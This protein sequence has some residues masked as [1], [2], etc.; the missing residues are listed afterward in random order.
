MDRES[1][2]SLYTG[3]AGRTMNNFIAAIEKHDAGKGGTSIA[4]PRGISVF[5]AVGRNPEWEIGAIAAS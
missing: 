5:K 1:P 2:Y 3:E 4:C